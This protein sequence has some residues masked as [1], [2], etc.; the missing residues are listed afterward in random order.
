M[1]SKSE[2]IDVLEGQ[3]KGQLPPPVI[4]TQ[5]GTLGMMERSGAYWPE[6]NFDKDKMV[7]LA[8]QPHESFGLATARVP[9]D[10]VI[11]AEAVGCTIIPGTDKTQP[12]VSGSPWRDS[13]ETVPDFP[14]DIIS[15]EEM[16]EFPHLRNIINSA[17]TLHRN[18]DLFVTS[19]CVCGGGIVM[20][21]LGMENMIMGMMMDPET[22]RKYLIVMADYSAAYAHELSKVSDNVCVIT[23]FL[24]DIIPPDM[25]SF[26]VPLNRKVFKAIDSS[27]SMI[28]NCGNT[29]S[30]VDDLVSL[31]SDIISLEMSS[32]PEAYMRKIDGRCKVLGCISPLGVML[33]GSPE[34]VKKKALWSAELGVDLVG[35]EC[36]LGPLT[37][38]DNVNALSH[39]RD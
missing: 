24:S 35:P 10:V 37:P 20:H 31:N 28:H 27:Y 17:E 33:N 15:I 14:K 29:L 30:N 13:S 21:M 23:D 32:N 1:N 26:T 18:E 16:L 7:R 5:T 25:I 12:A 11:Q 8:L 38:D 22:V 4:F 6:A 2:I 19:M 39:Y 34:D 36:G 3:Y 9:F